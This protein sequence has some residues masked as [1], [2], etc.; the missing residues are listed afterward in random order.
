ML[1]ALDRAGLRKDPAVTPAEFAVVVAQ[2][3]P[4]VAE[5]VA[6]LTGSYERVRYGGYR[7]ERSELRMLE[8]V[9]ATMRRDIR[10][11]RPRTPPVG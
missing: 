8:L 5:G 9:S 3:V 1:L 10:A 6:V 4:E 2:A 11:W 7:L